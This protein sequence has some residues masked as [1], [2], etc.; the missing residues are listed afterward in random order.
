MTI[1]T[2]LLSN[3]DTLP[4]IGLG[5]Y[6]LK[7]E[8]GAKVIQTAL[9]IGYRYLDTAYNYENEATVGKAI[10][11]SHYSR[12]QVIVASKLPGR[13]QR[14][15]EALITIQESLYRAQ[16]DYYDFYLI[17]WPNPIQDH[18]VEAWEALIEAKKRGYIKELGTSNFLPEHID[19]LE[20]ETG[21]LPLINQV[22]THP[23]FQQ[24]TQRHYD[25][26]KKILT[27]SWSPLG[28]ANEKIPVSIMDNAIIKELAQKYHKSTGQI[29][30]RWHTQIGNMPLPKST[31]KQRLEEN[32]SI[33]NFELSAEDM[34]MMKTLDRQDGR[35]ANQ[36]PATYEEF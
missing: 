8:A 18:Y 3:G 26:E 25:K 31:H 35:L 23:Y 16:L 21:V 20:K 32:L 28:R 22:E 17:H 6:K 19:R 2:F 24:E 4:Q 27:Q 36:D 15:Q 11:D 10:R 9:D 30:L 29:I 7:G 1:P 33:F 14:Y 5:T 12:D 13:Y 34:A